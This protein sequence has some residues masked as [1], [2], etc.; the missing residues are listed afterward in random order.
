MEHQ[1]PVPSST[2]ELNTSVTS[3][4]RLLCIFV[5]SSEVPI[6][7]SA[8][9]AE[10]GIGH[11][12]K[13]R[14][15][16]HH[17]AGVVG[18]DFLQ[19]AFQ[20]LSLL[21]H[22]AASLPLRF[23]P[24]PALSLLQRLEQGEQRKLHPDKNIGRVGANLGT[25]INRGLDALCPGSFGNIF[26]AHLRFALGVAGIGLPLVLVVDEYLG[27]VITIGRV[28]HLPA[29]SFPDGRGSPRCLRSDTGKYW[30]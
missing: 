22:V 17:V 24:C 14:K 9:S 21:Q 28:T 29:G 7:T 11:A 26:K 20:R 2:S 30:Q 8:S 15:S 6:I 25:V 19:Q 5:I 18:V 23:R 13:L 16:F 27:A 4:S 1:R 3:A 10:F 12:A